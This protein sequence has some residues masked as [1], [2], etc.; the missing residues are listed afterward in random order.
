MSIFETAVYL[1]ASKEL[2]SCKTISV[3]KMMPFAAA[4]S[5]RKQESGEA[6]YKSIFELSQPRQN[7][8]DS[9]VALL[10]CSL[11]AFMLLSTD[12]IFF[13]NY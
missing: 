1:R 12:P 8:S 10:D 5:R 11:P 2:P 4:F 13:Q 7:K 6:K 9:E 3:S